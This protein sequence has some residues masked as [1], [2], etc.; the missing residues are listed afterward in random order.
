M[1]KLHSLTRK[2]IT[3]RRGDKIV[4]KKLNVFFEE[5]LNILKLFSRNKMYILPS[6]GPYPQFLQDEYPRILLSADNINYLQRLEEEHNLEESR[7]EAM[8]L[9]EEER[10]R[11]EAKKFVEQIHQSRLKG[12]MI[13]Y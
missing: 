2:S 9:A 7:I 3:W 8:R 6:E 4:R 5:P 13:H 10:L 11:S 1:L 12:K